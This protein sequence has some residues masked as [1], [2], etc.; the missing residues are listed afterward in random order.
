[1]LAEACT[2]LALNLVQASIINDLLD[3]EALKGASA[4]DKASQL[5]VDATVH[6]VVRM[7]SN[8]VRSKVRF[9]SVDFACS[10]ATSAHALR[11]CIVPWIQGL[12]LVHELPTVHRRILGDEQAI[13]RTVMNMVRYRNTPSSSR[14]C[15]EVAGYC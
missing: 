14:T 11:M 15:T 7:F 9:R 13:K 3:F 2:L 4:N 5:D 8:S 6:S 1:V 12:S 10:A